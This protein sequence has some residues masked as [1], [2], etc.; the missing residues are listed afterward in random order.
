MGDRNAYVTLTQAKPT[1]VFLP[2]PF[3]EAASFLWDE[4]ARGQGVSAAINQPAR[5]QDQ[6]PFDA[7]K[8]S[9]E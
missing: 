6:I 4:Q 9:H 2:L 7:S 8:G 3:K 1:P 5:H